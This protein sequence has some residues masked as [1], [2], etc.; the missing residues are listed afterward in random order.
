MMFQEDT[1]NYHVWSYRSY[2]VGF[3]G[4]VG[5]RG[6]GQ[7]GADDHRGC[8]KQFGMVAPLLR[9]VFQSRAV[10][11]RVCCDRI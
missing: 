7:R 3:A 8:A 5:R 6:A 10:I 9:G 1:K 4:D 11:C 2:L